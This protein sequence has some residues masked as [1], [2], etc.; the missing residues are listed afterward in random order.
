M[1]SLHRALA[2]PEMTDRSGR[3]A[4]D[5]HFDMSGILDQTLDIDLVASE[6]SVRFGTA[7]GIG[8]IEF[9]RRMH[10]PHPAPAAS[11][12]CLDHDCAT[13]TKCGQKGMRLIK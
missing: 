11:G 7:A 5:L 8:L 10:G 13:A 6:G 1:A 12:D 3:I 2:L 9:C 4:D